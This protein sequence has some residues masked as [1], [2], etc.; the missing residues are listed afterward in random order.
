[1]DNQ[2]EPL[3]IGEVLSVDDSAQILIGHRT[4]RVGEFAEALRTQLEYGIQGWSSDKNAW[5]SEEGIPCEV[6]RFSAQG[7]QRGKVRI[8]L[9]FCPQ[10]FEDIEEDQSASSD[11][12]SATAVPTDSFEELDLEESP[13]DSASF[14][15][16][17]A[18]AALPDKFDDLDLEDSPIHSASFDQ[19]LAPAALADRSHELDLEDSPISGLDELDLG[20]PSS[21]KSDEF[22]LGAAAAAVAAAAA[23]AAVVSNF[24]LEQD[25]PTSMYVEMEREDSMFMPDDEFEQ[26]GTPT[27]LDDDFDLGE[28][29]ESIE[30]ELELVDAPRASD[31]DLLDLGEMSTGSDD[32]FDLG[33][34]TG[35][36][37]EFDLGPMSTGSDDE[38]DLG[39]M[40]TGSDDEFDLGQMSASGEGEFQFEDISFNN[41]FEENDTNSLLDDVWED[42]N[43][44]SWK[45]N[46]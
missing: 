19:E 25:A 8:N 10:D 29:S 20:E 28:I 6:L 45:N 35:N 24:E 13:I 32:E 26:A 17:L 3:A 15:A 14:D 33:M 36:D 27:S 9:E 40:S 21:S 22:E 46:Q 39:P 11:Q 34:S 37:D 38:F 4:F 30:Q 16:G 31:D 2:F 18:T 43:Q 7:W 5:F 12:W 42:M 44:A 41:E 23:A 1:V